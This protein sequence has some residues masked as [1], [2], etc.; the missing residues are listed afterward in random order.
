MAFW[1]RDY[2]TRDLSPGLTLQHDR[3]NE[4]IAGMCLDDS[5]HESLPITNCQHGYP[6]MKFFLIPDIPLG[7]FSVFK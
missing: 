7:L 6:Y 2:C 1:G 5:L 3:I 4:E